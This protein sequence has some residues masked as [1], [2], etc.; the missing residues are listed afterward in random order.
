MHPF[1]NRS[2]RQKLTL[3]LMA[4]SSTALLLAGIALAAY[5]VV[6]FRQ[7]MV[8]DLSILADSIGVNV[9]AALSF[10]VQASGEEILQA[11]RVQPRIETATI[12][13]ADGR[14]FARYLRQ[15]VA[16]RAAPDLPTEAGYAF[17]EDHLRVYR[18]IVQGSDRL[19]TIYIEAD[20]EELRGRLRRFALIL[21]LVTLASAAVAFL[22][23]AR[24][25]GLVLKPLR[26]AIRHVQAIGGGRYDVSIDLNRQD[27]IGDMLRALDHMRTSLVEGTAMR[28]SE[29]RFS[30]PWRRQRWRSG[31]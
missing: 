20:L 1:R 10:N 26:R 19:G 6:T 28:A 23:T 16:T 7:K 27:E 12:F 24:L 13:D 14:V 30:W 18:R 5:D 31:S 29:E 8:Q 17:G 21:G 9:A 22:L 25:I 4:T 3:V 15:G 11:L 2:I